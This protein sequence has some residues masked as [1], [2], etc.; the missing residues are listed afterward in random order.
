MAGWLARLPDVWVEGE[1][2][3]LQQQSRWALAFLT[4]K[5]PDGG[6]SLPARDHAARGST[7]IDP[8]LRAGDRVHALRPRRAVPATRPAPLPGPARIERYGLGLV[9]RRIEELRKSAGWP[10]ACSPRSASGRCRSCRG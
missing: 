2:A 9:L 3:E 6:S 1:V 7:Q 8:P 5:D 10:R 4:L